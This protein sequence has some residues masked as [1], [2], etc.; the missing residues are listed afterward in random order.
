MR[1][2]VF[3]LLCTAAFCATTS[4]CQAAEPAAVKPL[5]QAHAHNDYE[6]A[7]PL[8]D[9]LDHGFCSVEADIWLTPEGL[10]IGHDRKDLKPGRTLQSLYLDPL[11]ER[12]KTNGERVYRG[13]PAFYLLIDV[14]TEAE[15]TYAELDKVLAR[16]ADI[17]TVTRD[18]KVESKAVTAILSGNR[19]SDTIAKQAVR[20]VGIDGRPE[21]LDANPP[22]ELY[23]WISANWTLLFKW[24]GEGPMPEGEREKLRGLV[25]RAHEQRRKIR[26]WGTAENDAMWRELHAAGVDYINTDKLAELQEFFLT[27]AGVRRNQF[28]FDVF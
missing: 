21:N 19:A 4:K 16:Y 8:L 18:G 14:K 28:N 17:L 3:L 20:Y 6:H 1:L 25:K 23:P 7:R 13:G 22:A 27:K 26:F 10:L 15:A 2:G 5:P 9:A 12:I 11:R 24:N